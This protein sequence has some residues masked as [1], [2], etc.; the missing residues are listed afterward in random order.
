[1][2]ILCG[3]DGED[4]RYRGGR[5]GADARDQRMSLIGA[6][7]HDMQRARHDA[8]GRERCLAGQ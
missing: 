8:I 5:R 6:A 1:M 2:Q 4:A 3:V 7:K